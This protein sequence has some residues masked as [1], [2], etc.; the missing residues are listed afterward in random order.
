MWYVLSGHFR[1]RADNEILDAPRGS[2]V[3]M[4]RGTRHCFQNVSAE[5][6]RI[7]VMFT[8]SGMERWFEAQAALPLPFDPEAYARISHDNWME[9]AGP[10]LR[11]SHPR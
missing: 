2:F 7:L 8:P 9:V 3:F 5:T 6:A 1:F 10:P 11:E 4:P